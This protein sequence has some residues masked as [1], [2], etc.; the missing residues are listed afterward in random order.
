MNEPSNSTGAEQA[1]SRTEDRPQERIA[2]SRGAVDEAAKHVVGRYTAFL[3]VSTYLAIVVG[4]TT[5]EHLLRESGLRLPI[6]N[7][8]LPIVP[9]YA[10]MP[11]LYLILHANLVL[12]LC[13]LSDKLRSLDD[14]IQKLPEEVRRDERRLVHPFAFAHMWIG[15]AERVHVR[16]LLKAAVWLTIIIGPL[17]LLCWIQRQFLPYHSVL[18]TWCH[19]LCVLADLGLLWVYWPA[20]MRRPASR[21]RE[22]YDLTS[23]WQLPGATLRLCA[24]VLGKVFRWTMLVG[25]SVLVAVYALFIASVPGRR[26]DLIVPPGGLAETMLHRNLDLREMTLVASPPPPEVIA[27]Y[28]HSR[29]DADEAWRDHAKGLIL[30]RRDLRNADFFRSKL[31]T[32]DLREA[33]L[34][35]ADLRDAKL[36]GADLQ[37]AELHGANLWGAELHGT[38]LFGA[39]LHGARLFEAKLHGVN[40]ESAELHGADLGFAELHGANLKFAELHG[41]NLRF[42]ELHGAN[43]EFAKLHGATLEYAQLDGANLR[44]ALLGG[45]DF[46]GGLLTRCDLRGVHVDTLSDETWNRITEDIK[47]AVVDEDTRRAVLDA[48]EDARLAET[49][50]APEFF[51][52]DVALSN[53]YHKDSEPFT[54]WPEPKLDVDAYAQELASYLADLACEN[55]W[56]A[57]ALVEREGEGYGEPVIVHAVG[58]ALLEKAGGNGCEAVQ[59]VPAELL[60]ELE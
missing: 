17:F 54:D 13:L 58:N 3:L 31:L 26:M 33:Q 8:E 27:A 47:R 30:Q 49:H 25:T 53:L 40:L 44:E 9:F 2:L 45:A 60:K 18:I 39:E 1:D 21:S 32:A 57:E 12:L 36:H 23:A 42:A 4:S 59:E 11:V 10:V 6:F 24:Y 43:L 34:Q 14:A 16:G 51:E 55:R 38:N 50:F 35:G 48:I 46:R 20:I 56:V 7:V 41:A 19:R 15:S 37:L 52:N 5:D 22:P 28:V 29:R